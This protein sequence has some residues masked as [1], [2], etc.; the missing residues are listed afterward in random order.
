[1]KL[2][3]ATLA[4][5]AALALASPAFAQAA[6]DAAKGKTLFTQRC[7]TCH[8]VVEGQHKPTGPNLYKII[9]RKAGSAPGY[10]Y[11]RAL[12]ASTIVWDKAKLD[13]FLANPLKTVPGASMV[14]STTNATER[15]N[16]IAYLTS[17]TP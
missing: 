10:R 13:A 6:G 9:G 15:A 7:L 2:A 4:A 5:S 14:I 17:P 8:T 1:M 3:L 12:A 16:L 11:S